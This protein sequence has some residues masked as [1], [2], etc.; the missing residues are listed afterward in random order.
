[1]IADRVR[2]MIRSFLRIEPPQGRTITIT[3]QL[4]YNA[5]AARNRIWYR[6]QAGELSEFYKQIPSDRT[7]FWTAVP[8]KGMEIRKIHTGLPK[9][10]VDVLTGVVLADM[11]DIDLPSNI[12]P[13]WKEIATG[14]DFDALMNT[15]LTQTLYIGDGAFKIS[16]DTD[17]SPYPIIEFYSGDRV[18]FI[19]Q[20]GRIREV[21]FKTEYTHKGTRYMLHEIYGFGYV[22]YEL[23]HDETEVPLTALPQ[24]ENL[25]SVTFDKSYCMAVPFKIFAG[26]NDR[27]K[28]VFDGKTGNFDSLDEV[29]SQWMHALR[30]SRPMKFMPPNLVPKNPYTGENLSP[31]AFDNVFIQTEGGMPENGDSNKPELIQSAIPHDSY[32]ATYITAL[33]LCLQGIISPSTLGIDTKKLDN[34][35]AQRE[36]EK[37]TLYTRNAIVL[38]LQNTLPKLVQ[39][40]FK[41]Y[42]DMMGK[43]FG[44]FDVDV[45]FGE[46][47]NPSFESQVETVGKAKT[48]GIMSVE[49]CV[50][51]LY[52]DTR[53][54]E[55]KAAEVERIKAEQGV[56]ETSEPSFS[57]V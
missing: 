33:D 56:Q 48:Q 17:I 8:T 28:S 41:V 5:N 54:D 37:T 11:N 20:R 52:G 55:W 26:D 57:E 46:Y 15:A 22:Y 34:A 49:A 3:E 50:E 9:L 7:S 25:T 1:M 18:E 4:D 47:A 53:D 38:A 32:L 45:P 23:Y 21:V 42:G 36:K 35:E 30:M 19:T 44:D 13:I 14:N 12:N 31:N 39:A 40:V 2:N 10:I 24:T 43:N 51:E 29:W 6:G 16:I 27:G